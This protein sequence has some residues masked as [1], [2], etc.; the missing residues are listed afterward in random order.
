[1]YM[2][3]PRLKALSAYQR[4]L[5]MP[6]QSFTLTNLSANI[7]RNKERLEQIKAQTVSDKPMRVIQARRDGACERCGEAISTG[8]WIGKFLDGWVLLAADGDAWKAACK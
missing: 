5:A 6:A 1:M 2:Y 7:R 3:S 8:D 4:D